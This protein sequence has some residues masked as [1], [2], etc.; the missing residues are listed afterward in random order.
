MSSERTD[1][2]R[3]EQLLRAPAAMADHGFTERVLHAARR[4]R[5]I[6]RA[7]FGGGGALWFGLA[8]TQV[9]TNTLYD[10]AEQLVAWTA[11][12]ASPIEQRVLDGDAFSVLTSVAMTLGSPSNLA[13]AAILALSL[14]AL[15]SVQIRI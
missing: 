7:V 13:P 15:L 4:R 8:L 5:R 3:L 12:V 14:Y 1:M 2:D 9:S 10:H 6:R 11:Q